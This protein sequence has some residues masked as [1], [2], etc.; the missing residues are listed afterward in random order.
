M[1]MRNAVN[2]IDEQCPCDMKFIGPSAALEEHAASAHGAEAS[3]PGGGIAVPAKN[4]IRVCDGRPVVRDAD[5]GHERSTVGTLASC[6]VAMGD[7]IRWQHH[8]KRYAATQA[9]S[10]GGGRRH[11]GGPAQQVDRLLPLDRNPSGA[12]YALGVGLGP[13]S[14]Y[15]RGLRRFTVCSRRDD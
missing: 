13:R 12:M 1:H 11:F 4:T 6:A 8:G 9:G 5:P 7:P 10:G 2:R 15:P 14:G 3:L